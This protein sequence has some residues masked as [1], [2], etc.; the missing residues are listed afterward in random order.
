[1]FHFHEFS[2]LKECVFV[3]HQFTLITIITII[4]FITLKKEK[5]IIMVMPWILDEQ[6]ETP[7]MNVRYKN[8]S[9]VISQIE[10]KMVCHQDKHWQ[11]NC[12]VHAMSYKY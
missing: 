1:M 10:N 6:G 5:A 12:Y 3:T 8:L 7:E 11:K 9:G 4:Q 2:V